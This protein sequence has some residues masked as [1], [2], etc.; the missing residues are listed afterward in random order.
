MYGAVV[1]GKIRLFK[2]AKACVRLSASH[3]RKLGKAV[4]RLS[5]AVLG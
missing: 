5:K 3:Y 1:L 4:L 2:S